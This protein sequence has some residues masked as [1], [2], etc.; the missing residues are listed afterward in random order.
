M[1]M[2]TRDPVAIAISI[3]STTPT[4]PPSSLRKSLASFGVFRVFR[5]TVVLPG[6][7]P[8]VTGTDLA[9]ASWKIASTC[10]SSIGLLMRT[11]WSASQSRMFALTGVPF[12][13]DP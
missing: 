10:G 1:T 2:L 3:A 11:C 4:F 8:A 6:T 13:S 9:S 12:F 5:R 7:A